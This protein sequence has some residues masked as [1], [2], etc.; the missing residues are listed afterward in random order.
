M[1]WRPLIRQEVTGEMI[2]D[3]I[4]EM[5]FAEKREHQA[6]WNCRQYRG[7]GLTFREYLFQRAEV[8]ILDESA[9]SGPEYNY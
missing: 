7:H 5:T 1:T 4:A 3:R 6:D 9:K 2:N 8:L